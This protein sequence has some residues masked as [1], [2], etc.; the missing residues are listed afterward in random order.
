MELTAAI[1][2]LKYLSTPSDVTLVTD[3]A[4]LCNTLNRN[5]YD[6]W[7]ADEARGHKTKPRPNMDL[8]RQL[9]GL[10]SF[11]NVKAVKV[12]GHSGDYW[13]HRAD[14]LADFARRDQS[15]SE[16]IVQDWQEGIRCSNKPE[17]YVGQCTL[18]AGHTGNCHFSNGR[19]RNGVEPY[20]SEGS[21]ERNDDT[22]RV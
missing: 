1:E 11:H 8:W 17:S 5:W 9:V 21:E 3:S 14:R 2:G 7:F 16:E 6:R 19:P 15:S 10:T 12:K 22:V 13:N 4:Y 20:G 18:H